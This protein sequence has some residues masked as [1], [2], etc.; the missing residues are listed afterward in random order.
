MEEGPKG[1]DA[2]IGTEESPVAITPH[3]QAEEMPT[4]KE[5]GSDREGNA[6]LG[7]DGGV[8]PPVPRDEDHPIPTEGISLSLLLHVR[9]WAVAAAQHRDRPLSTTDVCELYVKPSTVKWRES[10]TSSLVL[11][12]SPSSS[13]SFSLSDFSLPH[14]ASRFLT[15]L[16]SFVIGKS[17]TQSKG[18]ILPGTSGRPIYLCHMRGDTT[19]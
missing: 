11:G 9:D 2:V 14:L 3:P 7:E 17:T 10:F 16:F 19:S 13:S 1:S 6:A 8:C 4:D 12:S 18:L 15:Y 5:E